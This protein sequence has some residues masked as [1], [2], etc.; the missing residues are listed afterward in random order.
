MATI[1]VTESNFEQTIKSGIV[2]LDFWA[3]WCG[4]CRAFAP[5]FE[6]ASQ[7]H[8]DVVFGKVDTEAQQEIAAA[9]NVQSIPTVAVFRDGILLAAQ[10]G[11][12]PA[13]ALDELIQKVRAVDMDDVRSKIAA[14][15]AEHAAKA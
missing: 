12:L 5:I 2:L 8:P 9:F 15:E 13:P 10:P 3:A 6:A 1:E 14:H 4:P 11:M 7:K